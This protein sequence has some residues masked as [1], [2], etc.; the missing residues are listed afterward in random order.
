M[1]NVENNSKMLQYLPKVTECYGYVHY[2]YI[3]VSY[4][5]EDCT[6]YGHIPVE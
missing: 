3:S 1:D 4:C 5:Y 6:D 2:V